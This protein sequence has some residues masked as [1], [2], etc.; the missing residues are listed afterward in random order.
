MFKSL[1][2][3]T[4]CL[5]RGPKLVYTACSPN[6]SYTDGYVFWWS[7]VGK[8]DDGNSN[9]L[10]RFLA[11]FIYVYVPVELVRDPNTQ[12]ITLIIS[13]ALSASLMPKSNWSVVTFPR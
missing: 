3:L 6:N 7:T 11:H 9:L 13:R 2:P 4:F 5:T 12:V 10:V 8:I 1:K